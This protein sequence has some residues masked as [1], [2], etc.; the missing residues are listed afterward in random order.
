MCVLPCVK[1]CDKAF[2]QAYGQ[3][4]G[5]AG[6]QAYGAGVRSMR[7]HSVLH[8]VHVHLLCPHV[9]RFMQCVYE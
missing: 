1:A 9:V 7:A 3:A 5:Q 4:Y 8:I 2:G 6:V